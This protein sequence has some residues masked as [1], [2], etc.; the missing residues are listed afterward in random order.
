MIRPGVVYLGEKDHRGKVSFF[1]KWCQGTCYQHDFSPVAIQPGWHHV[2]WFL[3]CKLLLSFSLHFPTYSLTGNHYVQPILKE[4]R[5]TL[6]LLVIPFFWLQSFPASGSFPMSRLSASGG[7]SI[8]ASASASVLPMNIQG[9][10]P[11]GLT[12]LISLQA[13]GLSEPSPAPQFEN[14]S[15]LA[16]SL[17]YGPTLTSVHNYW[18]NH[19]FQ[20]MDLCQQSN[21]SAIYYTV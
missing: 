2:Q 7:Q 15:S 21:V 3:H 20:Y 12:G 6:Y 17:L 1:T 9:W 5:V 11:L 18:K 19:S 10:F 4:W 14:I 16:L 8:G 13:R